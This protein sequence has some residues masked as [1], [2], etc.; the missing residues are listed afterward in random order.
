MSWQRR[1]AGVVCLL[2]T[3]FMTSAQTSVPANAKLYIPDLITQTNQVWPSMPQPV[4]LAGQV[5]QETCIS[6]TWPSCWNPHTELK[7]SREYGFG[8]GQLTVTAQFNNFTALQKFN[9]PTIKTWKWE[10]RYDPNMQLRA[11]VL[12]D[13]VSFNEFKAIGATPT[14]Q[15]AFMYSAYNGGAGGLI[16]DIKYCTALPNCNHKVWFGNVADNS[17]KQKTAV[18]GYG[19]SFF[20]INRGYVNNILNVRSAKYAPY[21]PAQH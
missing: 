9:D 19:Q 5:E 21:F 8:L 20:Q 14:D 3:F 16:Q 10:N 12:M 7:T 2:F 17:L 18:S 1:L 15:L 4:T 11:L 13:L 6:L